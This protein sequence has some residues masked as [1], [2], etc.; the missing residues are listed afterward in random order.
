MWSE[1]L[2]F[3]KAKNKADLFFLVSDRRGSVRFLSSHLPSQG[4]ELALKISPLRRATNSGLP[5][6]CCA[7]TVKLQEKVKMLIADM[8]SSVSAATRND[9]CHLT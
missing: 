4:L 8:D 6:S 7:K 2:P 3:H 9:L 5:P 1:T